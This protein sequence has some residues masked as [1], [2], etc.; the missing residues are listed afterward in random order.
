MSRRHEFRRIRRR[1]H[2]SQHE[3]SK[4]ARLDRSKLSLFE[5]G[6]IS[7]Q[8]EEEARLEAVLRT[9]LRGAART[10]TDSLDE[11]SK[12]R[13]SDTPL[14]SARAIRCRG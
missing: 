14:L 4:Q 11:L 13:E 2:W 3:T 5:N 7:L 6:H 10:L 9:G 1:L 8:P 12:A